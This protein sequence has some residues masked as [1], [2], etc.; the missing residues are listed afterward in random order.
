MRLP[1]ESY[2]MLTFM[3]H[4]FLIKLNQAH[5]CLTYDQKSF[6]LFHCAANTMYL[7]A[8]C[9]LDIMRTVSDD[10]EANFFK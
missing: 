8:K 7:V 10:L 5:L 3:S 4:Y 9:Q 2:N 1:V 6:F